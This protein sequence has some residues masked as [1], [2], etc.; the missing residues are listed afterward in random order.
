[1]QLHALAMKLLLMTKT[2]SNSA[3]IPA[4]LLVFPTTAHQLAKLSIQL[5]EQATSMSTKSGSHT[6]LEFT[7]NFQLRL[8]KRL[9]ME[10]M[11]LLVKSHPISLRTE[12]L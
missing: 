2:H 7:K 12:E 11:N 6:H 9:M 3:S 5:M 8:I 1:M 4:L 10:I